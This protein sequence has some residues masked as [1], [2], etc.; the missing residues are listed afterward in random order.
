MT[1]TPILDYAREHGILWYPVLLRVYKDDKGM[2]KKDVLVG[3]M[4]N[5][6]GYC[7]KYNDWTQKKVSRVLTEARMDEF[8]EKRA[9]MEEQANALDGVKWVL[10]LNTC[11]THIIDCDDQK[12]CEAVARL[13]YMATMPYYL[14]CSKS[15]PKFFIKGGGYDEGE[16]SKDNIKFF[17]TSKKNDMLEIQKGQWSYA[18]LD[19][20]VYNPEKAP[21]DYPIKAMVDILQKELV[22]LGF[23]EYT[24]ATTEK[25]TKQ[26]STPTA[27]LVSSPPIVLENVAPSFYDTSIPWLLL[28]C[29]KD[30][31]VADRDDWFKVACALKSSEHPYAYAMFEVWSA[32]CPEK[33]IPSNF[34]QGGSDYSTW[35]S[36][37]NRKCTMGSLHYWAKEDN[38]ELYAKICPKNYSSIKDR[39]E[40]TNFKVRDIVAFCETTD[41][42]GLLIRDKKKYCDLYEN[43]L[44]ETIVMTKEGLEKQNKSFV[45][46]WLKDPKMRTYDR[47]VFDPA[48]KHTAHEYNRFDGWAVEQ[49]VN[50]TYDQTA[51]DDILWFIKNQYADNQE[52]FYQ[53]LIKWFAS[54]LQRPGELTRVCPVIKSVQGI[55][56]NM[57][58]EFIGRK[59]LGPRYYHA[60]A[61]A[62]DIVGKYNALMAEKIL[63]IWDETS[64][65]DSWGM[66]NKIKEIIAN[67]TLTIKTKHIN[68]QVYRNTINMMSFCNV[69]CPFIFEHSDRRFTAI[70]SKANPLNTEQIQ[71]YVRLFGNPNTAYSFY[72]YLLSVELG[73]YNLEKNRPMTDF[74]V[75]CKSVSVPPLLTFLAWYNEYHNEKDHSLHTTN[76][77]DAY[78]K[79]WSS[80]YNAG[81]NMMSLKKFSAELAKIPG[82]S[83]GR[84]RTNGRDISCMGFDML[85]VC[86]HLISQ[87]AKED[88]QNVPT[89]KHSLLS[90]IIID[91]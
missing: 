7:P 79:V 9:Y 86:E 45:K 50:P 27:T 62:D 25:K 44:Y 67:D 48:N 42:D 77:Y 84:D 22:A 88:T 10:A 31:R 14:S 83:K 17:K 64:Q 69:G 28:S 35:M 36:I 12:V 2:T 32:R 87:H 40:L 66:M 72:M 75:E 54:L 8:I 33:Y 1:T 57:L 18:D 13:D 53:Y 74:Y 71:H 11:D 61:N 26:T 16:Y 80:S 37:K 51:V 82:I 85:T 73:D 39:F 41:G 20:E 65:G 24:D 58:M 30:S 21:V 47:M 56:K 55:G 46:D 3:M 52:E 89:V 81:K 68:D 70:E 19:T 38:P 34:K 76:L 91:D 23:V 5:L 43:L 29:L 4:K 63:V 59:I 78:Y 15:M 60:T 6:L 90:D 49:L